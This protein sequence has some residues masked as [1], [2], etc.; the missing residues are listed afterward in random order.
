VGFEAIPLFA[1]LDPGDRA[2]VAG[3]AEVVEVGEGECVAT[4]NDF[5]YSF[6]AIEE[7]T[8]DVRV[9]DR[10]VGG[11]GPGDFFGEIALLCTGRRTAQVVSTSPMKMYTLFDRDF[12]ELEG[13][14]PSLAGQLRRA[15]GER[16]AAARA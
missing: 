11:L 2:L 14:I 8:A 13:R 15:A 16:L 6:F 3:Y 5:G 10:T 4:Q 9:D 12:R 7:G 1:S